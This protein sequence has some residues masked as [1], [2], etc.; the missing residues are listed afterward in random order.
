[1]LAFNGT[2]RYF[3][4]INY[5]SNTPILV[6]DANTFLVNAISAAVT[7]EYTMN[8][9]KEIEETP[10]LVAWH[11]V[12]MAD[13]IGETIASGTNPVGIAGKTLLVWEFG[14]SAYRLTTT[15]TFK[16]WFKG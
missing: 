1:M 3:D 2:T 6:S 15:G 12:P 5:V 8:S 11:S 4:Q 7:I 13:F 10:L 16:A 14:P 9:V